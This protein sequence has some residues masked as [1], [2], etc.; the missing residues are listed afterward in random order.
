MAIAVKGHQRGSYLPAVRRPG[1]MAGVDLGGHEDYSSP[2]QR[3]TDLL[4]WALRPW[5][6]R[7]AR[8]VSTLLPSTRGPSSTR[9]PWSGR[10]CS[11][12]TP[13]TR[14]DRGRLAAALRGPRAGGPPAHP[15]HRRPATTRS[16]CRL[17]VQTREFALELEVRA[18]GRMLEAP[19]CLRRGGP[20]RA[21]GGRGL[22]A[23]RV[24]RHPPGRPAAAG[25]TAGRGVTGPL[26]HAT[27]AHLR[28]REPSVYI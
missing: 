15:G 12:A 26:G 22:P 10:P 2:E 19:S 6:Y 20:Y 21:P 9:A 18:E 17:T 1:M 16:R 5:L 28:N 14:W 11:T 27:R 24:R 3:S 25:P 13:R 23:G 8:A 4:T 7:I